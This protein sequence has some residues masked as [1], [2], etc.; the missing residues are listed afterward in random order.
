MSVQ[1]ASNLP[2]KPK[3]QLSIQP[4]RSSG[5]SQPVQLAQ[6]PEWLIRIEPAQMVERRSADL[7]GMSVELVQVTHLR[8]SEMC[9]ASRAH[10]LIAYEQGLRQQGGM[11]TQGATTFILRDLRRKLT[12]MPAGY[13]FSEWH[14]PIRQSLFTCFHIDP[15]E[16]FDLADSDS[17]LPRLLSEQPV[18]WETVAELRRLVEGICAAN[19]H[20]ME[21][22]ATVLCHELGQIVCSHKP[23]DGQARGGLAPWRLHLATEYIEEHLGEYVSLI[24]LAGLVRLSPHHFCRAFK[25]SLGSSPC[26]YHGMRRLEQAKHLLA[27]PKVAVPEVAQRLGSTA[28]RRG[29][30]VT[31]TAFR[32]SFM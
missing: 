17:L 19:L 6:A 18:L 1:A 4:L 16:Q 27:N 8:K 11:R 14:M 21:A 20:Y 10:L 2:S 12:F 13:E 15:S 32:C 31:P 3:V 22:V 28:L 23:P 9:F 25:H 29:T 24:T 30:G 7:A 26:R 5:L